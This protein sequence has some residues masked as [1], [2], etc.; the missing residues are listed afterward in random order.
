MLRALLVP[1]PATEASS[2]T[3]CACDRRPLPANQSGGCL[4]SSAG[5]AVHAA[6]GR[7]CDPQPGRLH[8]LLSERTDG[9]V[10]AHLPG[11]RR[12]RLS[13]GVASCLVLQCPSS[14]ME[15]ALCVCVCLGVRD[16]AP[17]CRL[18]VCVVQVEN[19]LCVCCAPTQSCS[20]SEVTTLVLFLNAD[21]H[22]VRHQLKVGMVAQPL[23]QV[24][25]II[26]AGPISK[27][28]LH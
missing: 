7:V 26:P 13:A 8:A 28:R 15:A 22:S 17:C 19:G 18:C 23:I 2:V 20:M 5:V 12:R 14:Q 21:C 1:P 27:P 10:H 6:V 16:P 24:R 9:Q 3:V 4:P 25:V 11:R